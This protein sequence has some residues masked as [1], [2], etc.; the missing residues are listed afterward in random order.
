MQPVK[1]IRWADDDDT[2]L[3]VIPWVPLNKPFY[4]IQCFMEPLDRASEF[5]IDSLWNE[6][7]IACIIKSKKERQ[8]HWEM[9]GLDE[10]TAIYLD[11]YWK[12]KVQETQ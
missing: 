3:P 10:A 2:E 4:N 6:N 1:P 11:C 12:Q 7:V 9:R 5:Y 8:S